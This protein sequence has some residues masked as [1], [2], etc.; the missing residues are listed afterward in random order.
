MRLGIG[1]ARLRLAYINQYRELALGA[2]LVLAVSARVLGWPVTASELGWL[3]AWFV[4]AWGF[5]QFSGAAADEGWLNRIEYGYFVAELAVIT[6][7]ALASGAAAWLALLFYVVTVLY[8][9]MVLPRRLALSVYAVAGACFASLLLVERLQSGAGSAD[10][11]LAVLGVAAL[12]G[13]GLIGLTA[14]QFS[15]MLNRQGEALQTANRDLNLATQ[16][17]RLHRDHLEEMVARR[18]DDLERASQ[19]LRRANA[20]LMRLNELKSSFLANVSHELRTPLTSIRSFSEILLN[21]PDTEFATREEFLEIICSE[22]ERLTRLI[23]DVLDLAKIEAGK[24]EWRSQPVHLGDLARQSVDVMQV[25]ASQKGL[26]LEN[27][28][29]DDV[30]PVQADPDRLLQVFAN[31]ISN[32]VKFTDVGRIQ[33]GALARSDEVVVYVA[34]SGIGIPASELER[35]FDKFHQHG[36]TLTDKPTGTGLGLA[37]S[38]EIINRM[39]GRIWAESGTRAGST[40]YCALPIAPAPAQRVGRS[41]TP[42]ELTA[43]V[44]G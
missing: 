44:G 1:E 5:V 43:G 28:I 6:L 23:N 40:F 19:E 35:I 20:D 15:L 14:A 9:S 17:L 10:W 38:R 11:Q 21:Y 37:I 32:A 30:P 16:E 27:L 34:D 18:T 39:G 24:M 13:F 22:S 12:A 7:L 4:L 41:E 26:E 31:L 33:V 25:V 29:G 3:G 36:N 42:A 2:L 8:A